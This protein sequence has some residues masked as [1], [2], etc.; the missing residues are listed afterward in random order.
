[1]LMVLVRGLEGV[2]L[3]SAF[4]KNILRDARAGAKHLYFKH[5]LQ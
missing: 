2:V 3:E 1:M 5:G 4:N